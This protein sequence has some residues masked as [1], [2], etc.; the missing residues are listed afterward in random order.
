MMEVR[1]NGDR[2]VS[3]TGSSTL[4]R[5]AVNCSI[6]NL[7]IS[8]ASHASTSYW[9]SWLLEFRGIGMLSV[10]QATWEDARKLLFAL[11]LLSIFFHRAQHF[12]CEFA[13]IYM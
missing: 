3:R 4:I 6:P 11:S 5:N 12:P 2:G 13:S 10:R 9:F 7:S 1:R 8:I